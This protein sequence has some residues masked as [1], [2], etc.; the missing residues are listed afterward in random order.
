MAEGEI[1]F[2][3]LDRSSLPLAYPVA[4]KVVLLGKGHRGDL[5]NSAGAILDALVGA[6]ILLDDRLSCVSRLVAEHQPK[7]ELGCWVEI[8]PMG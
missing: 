6:G 3:V 7:G 1:I 8:E 5:D 2:Q 4:V